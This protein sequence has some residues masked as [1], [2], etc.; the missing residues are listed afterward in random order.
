MVDR[1]AAITQNAGISVDVGDG[2]FSGGRVG[3]A[4]V[5]RGV[6]GF[7]QQRPERN[8]VG[9]FGG[10]HDLQVDLASRVTEGCGVVGVG[11]ENPFA[12]WLIWLPH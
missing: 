6:P 4:D 5:E 9:A 2:A 7:C 10:V 11:H 8:A 12:L 3:E 1:V